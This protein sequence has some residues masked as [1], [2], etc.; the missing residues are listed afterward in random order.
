MDRYGESMESI[1][2]LSWNKR[3][4]AIKKRWREQGYICVKKY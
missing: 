3:G 1:K 2:I 4:K